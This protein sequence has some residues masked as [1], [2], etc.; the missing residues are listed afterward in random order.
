MFAEPV[1]NRGKTD[2]M[3][4]RRE[5]FR[6]LQDKESVKELFGEIPEQGAEKGDSKD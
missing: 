3:H 5:V 4:S 2:S 6:A 1:I